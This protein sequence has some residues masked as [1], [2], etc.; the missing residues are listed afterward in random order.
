MTPILFFHG[1]IGSMAQMQQMSMYFSQKGHLTRCVDL[2]GHGQRTHQQPFSFEDFAAAVRQEIDAFD[3]Q[4]V[5]LVGYSMGGY[6]AL[7]A[8]LQNANNIKGIVTF[9]TK[10]LWDE[11]AAEKQCKFLVPA[12]LTAKVPAFAKQLESEHGAG[13]AQVLEKTA[14]LLRRN[15]PNNLLSKEKLAQI[16]CPVLVSIGENDTTADV[17]ES[18]VVARTIPK[19]SF[20]CLPHTPHDLQKA[21]LTIL[22]PIIER[23]FA[24]T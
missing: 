23:F 19:G 9:G 24:T 3:G 17:Q 20:L 18:L 6:A 8:A 11:A 4:E 5:F 15:A 13:W 7:C 21:N 14:D 10:F 2:P 1:A 12:T 22:G 16:S